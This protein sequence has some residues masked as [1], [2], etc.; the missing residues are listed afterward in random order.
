M[1]DNKKVNTIEDIKKS[2]LLGKSPQ[3]P[4]REK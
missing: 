4:E 1:V 3:Y 2:A